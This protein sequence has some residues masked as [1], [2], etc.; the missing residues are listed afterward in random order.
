MASM[1]T[2]KWAIL[3]GPTEYQ[4]VTQLKYCD[5][6]VIAVSDTLRQ[7]LEFPAD[8]ILTFATGLKR[9]PIRDD[10]YHELGELRQSGL[11]KPDDLLLFYFSGHGFRDKKDYL[12]PTGA[13]P[14][15]L[16]LTGI[17]V[18]DLVSQLT[19]TGCKNVVMFVDAC[20]EVIDGARGSTSIGAETKEIVERAGVVS[21]FA[22]DP[23]ERSWEIDQLEHG[24][25]THC[26]LEAVKCRS[27]VTAEQVYDYLLRELPPLNAKY[28]KPPQRPYAVM[29]PVDKK[30]LPILTSTAIVLQSTRRL[31][32]LISQMGDL[33]LD[34]PRED[35]KYKYLDAAIEFLHDVKQREP[36][37]ED[38]RKLELIEQLCTKKVRSRTF[39]TLWEAIER[40]RGASDGS[41]KA[42]TGQVGLQ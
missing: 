13:T 25:F 16:K 4:H 2:D 6:D 24:S 29:Q 18:E 31:E 36:S 17:E 23:E 32:G 15:N 34:W 11:V 22:C 1:F 5:K 19:A 40:R 26:F 38:T 12:L 21:F 30:S 33:G 28:G 14:L 42:T 35:D 37:G 39:T 27:C 9:K 20:R 8:H 10:I 3:I 41:A 7:N